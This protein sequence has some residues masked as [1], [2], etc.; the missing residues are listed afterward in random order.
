MDICVYRYRSREDHLSSGPWESGAR[1]CCGKKF[2]R[3]QFAGLHRQ[4]GRAVKG[5]APQ[6]LPPT[7]QIDDSCFSVGG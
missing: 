6:N 1:F 4:P 2:S 3:A 7:P 5:K